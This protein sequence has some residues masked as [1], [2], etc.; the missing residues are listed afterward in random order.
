MRSAHRHFIRHYLEMVVAMFVSMGLLA[1]ASAGVEALTGWEY[2]A[3]PELVALKMAFDMSV[4]MVV[5]MRFRGSP[6]SRCC[7]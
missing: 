5:W 4:G 3:A 6:T 2:P 1:A 7:P